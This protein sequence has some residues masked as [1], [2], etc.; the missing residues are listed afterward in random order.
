MIIC[1]VCLDDSETLIALQSDNV[2]ALPI[3]HMIK[4]F[5]INVSSLSKNI[6][7]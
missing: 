3:I 7:L 4:E 6:R 5:T 2:E 1:R